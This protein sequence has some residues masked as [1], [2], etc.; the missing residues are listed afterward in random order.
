MRRHAG[1]VVALGML[2]AL[3]IAGAG[4]RDLVLF[5][6]EV[7][8]RE[9]AAATAVEKRPAAAEQP[10]AGGPEQKSKASDVQTPEE[11]LREAMPWI[12]W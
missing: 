5:K 11:M 9:R 7:P 1:Q 6:I 2:A 12:E 8:P 3:G 4:C 10:P